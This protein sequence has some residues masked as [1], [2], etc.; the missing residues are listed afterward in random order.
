MLSEICASLATHFSVGKSTDQ[1]IQT[2]KE[3]LQYNPQHPP[4]LLA[5]A[6][7]YM[8]VLIILICM[9]LSSSNICICTLIINILD[10]IFSR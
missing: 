7:L 4:V 6:N 5:L 8:Q 3:A 1:A 10:I 2:Y 9:H